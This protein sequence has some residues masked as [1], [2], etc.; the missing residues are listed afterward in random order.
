VAEARGQKNPGSVSNRILKMRKKYNLPIGTG[1]AKKSAAAAEGTTDTKVPMTP[2]KN[3]VT[4]TRG[5][6]IPVKKNKD[7]MFYGYN[8]DGDNKDALHNTS[9]ITVVDD[10][11]SEEG[12]DNSEEE[13]MDSET[14]KVE[15]DETEV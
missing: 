13:D 11:D 10:D 7:A 6:A 3:R 8:S 14:L 1:S 2:S 12:E 5:R 15:E 9:K 4:K